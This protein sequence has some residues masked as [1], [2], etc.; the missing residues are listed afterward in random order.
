MAGGGYGGSRNTDLRWGRDIGL[1]WTTAAPAVA[2]GAGVALVTRAVTAGRS[3]YV[4][5]FLFNSTE[6]NTFILNW[7]SAG[8]A[9]TRRFV[10]G[11]GGFTE[12]VMPAALNDGLPADGG[13]N[14]TITVLGAGAPA[15]VYQANILYGEV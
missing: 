8:V 4:Y 2:P 14:I 10:F 11:G 5:G 13:T 3:G 9:Y 1:S 7:T 15:S 6:A 12:D